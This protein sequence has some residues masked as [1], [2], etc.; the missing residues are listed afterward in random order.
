MILL[1]PVVQITTASVPH[2]LTQLGAD[3]A[4]VTVVA[5]GRDPIR[6]HAGDRLGGAEERLRGCHVAVLTERFCQGSRQRLWP[7]RARLGIGPPLTKG[8]DEDAV[9]GM[10]IGSRDRAPR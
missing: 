5:V 2:T 9:L 3:R 1:Q 7:T 8:A 4:G 6:G 10:R